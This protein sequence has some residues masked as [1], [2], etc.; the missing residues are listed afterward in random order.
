MTYFER[1]E[2]C[3]QMSIYDYLSLDELTVNQTLELRP[4]VLI[5]RQG[6]FYEVETNNIHETAKSVEGVLR[7]LLEDARYN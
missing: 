3:G 2:N 5:K 4:Q 7:L 1:I 6:S